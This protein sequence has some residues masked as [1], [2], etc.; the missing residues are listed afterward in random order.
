D[1]LIDATAEQPLG[2]PHQL[3]MTGDQIYAD[4]VAD[5]LLLMLTD[6]GDTLLG[7]LEAMPTQAGTPLFAAGLQPGTRTDVIKGAGFTTGDTRSHLMS[8]GEYIAMYLFAW[9]PTLW[10]NS[11]PLAQDVPRYAAAEF[12]EKE[13]LQI[14][15]Q[16]VLT[17]LGTLTKVRRALANIPS[18]MIC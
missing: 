8:L 13:S 16:R 11:L 10:P 4:E 15:Y 1:D 12:K 17:Y 9:S 3:L 7:W 5:V 2:R 18:Y 6:A 14:Q